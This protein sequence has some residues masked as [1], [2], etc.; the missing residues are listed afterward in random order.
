M[1]N[2]FGCEVWQSVGALGR[3][4]FLNRDSSIAD[5]AQDVQP[6]I[7]KHLTEHRVVCPKSLAILGARGERNSPN[8]LKPTID[9][10]AS[11]LRDLVYHGPL[12]IQIAAAIDPVTHFAFIPTLR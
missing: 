2:H 12:L 4:R 9:S 10:Q 7:L 8:P 1:K 5:R 11:A 3:I 6:S